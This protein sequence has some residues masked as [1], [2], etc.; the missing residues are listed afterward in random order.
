MDNQETTQITDSQV[1]EHIFG[2][3]DSNDPFAQAE[4]PQ[5]PQALSPRNNV[6]VES[7]AQP[8]KEND[9]VRFEYWQSEAD[10]R[11]NRISSLEDTNKKLQDQ[12]LK[13]FER[14]PEAQGQQQVPVQAK[15][16]EQ[17]FPPP[18]DKPSKP[19]GFD[20]TDAYS[21][22][23]SDSAQYLDN[24]ETWRDSMDEYNRLHVEYQGAVLQAEREE[25]K[26]NEETRAANRKQAEE[27][28]A[29][30]SELRDSLRNDYDAAPEAIDDFIKKMSDPASVTVENLWKLYQLD[31]GGMDRAAPVQNPRTE[32]SEEFKQTR[33]AQSVPSPMGVMP[34]S[35]REQAMSGEDRIMDDMLKD[36]KAQNPF[37]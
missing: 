20:R 29:R 14:P 24:V 23:S 32:P 8:Q 10:K 9:E 17:S 1:E 6:I 7:P 28:A 35:N 11:Q 34:S 37:D 12:L 19:Q 33:N 36:Y 2:T 25:M 16:E 13:N 4:E 22:P 26:A 21:D 18:P 27:S 3:S 30:D 5:E 31:H 15:E